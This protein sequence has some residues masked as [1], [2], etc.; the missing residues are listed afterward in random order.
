MKTTFSQSV[1]VLLSMAVLAVVAPTAS[2]AKPQ[3]TCKSMC[4]R[5]TDC[6]MPSYTKMCLDACKQYGYEASEAG[7]AQLVTFTQYS[8]KQIQSAVGGTDGQQHQGASPR[9]SA[10]RN[11]SPRPPSTSAPGNDDAAELDKLE[12]ELNDLDT[13]LGKDSDELERRS[14]G[15]R[16][17]A[18]GAGAPARGAGGSPT[19]RRPAQSG[20]SHWTCNAEGLSVYGFDVA[21]GGGDV[22]GRST[23][24]IPGNGSSK[25]AAASAAMSACGSLMTANLS[26]DRSMVLDASSEGQWGVRIEV[27]CHVTQCA[28]M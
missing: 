26:T 11:A 27:P 9:S 8:C 13:Q 21:S 5:L 2:D 18:R 4:Q 25:D 24:S 16:G 23:V 14:R 20:S 10:P 1:W 12:K 28:P 22:R 15:A 7:R 6:K 17:P 3:A 19:G